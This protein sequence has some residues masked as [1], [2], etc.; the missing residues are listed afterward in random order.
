MKKTNWNVVGYRR[1]NYT[2]SIVTVVLSLLALLMWGLKLGI[3]FTGGSLM[4]ISFTPARPSIEVV[5]NAIPKDLGEPQVAPIG[6]NG[7]AVR[8]S[9]LTEEQHQAVLNAINQAAIVVNAD[10]K[11]SED[12]FTSIGPTVG[13]ELKNKAIYALFIVLM[14]ILAYIAWAFRKVSHPVPSW[15]FGLAAIVALFHDVIITVGAFAA[16]GHFMGVE[17]GSLFITALLTVLGFSV[18]DT[19]VVF[20]RIRDNLHRSTERFSV[21]VNNSLNET[22][23]RSINTSLTTLL[24]L[25]TSIIFGGESV[26]FFVLALIIGISFGTYSSIFIASPLL[27]SWNAMKERRKA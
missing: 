27:V 11:L 14:A 10:T 13:V 24:V 25:F 5:T 8:M 20:D 2:F 9:A 12:R 6:E 19:I 17:V 18:H 23:G 22:F 1:I 16:L 3:D 21:I 4:E 15:Q 7:Y 26:R